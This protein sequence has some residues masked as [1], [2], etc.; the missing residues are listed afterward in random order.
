MRT[1]EGAEQ[2]GVEVR[3]EG[4]GTGSQGYVAV[5]ATC[6]SVNT[7]PGTCSHTHTHTG[8]QSSIH[9]NIH[10]YAQ[11]GSE[12]NTTIHTHM[13]TK[14][15]LD[16]QIPDAL[17][18]ILRYMCSHMPLSASGS[19]PA[20]CWNTASGWVIEVGKDSHLAQN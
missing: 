13:T 7:Y 2:E 20:S 5:T 3:E 15:H 11:T 10:V 17:M 1:G 19:F 8:P 16:I 18:N 12:T 4:H 14:G 6:P 9:T